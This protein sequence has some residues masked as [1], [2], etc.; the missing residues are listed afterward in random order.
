[1]TGNRK[2]LSIITSML[3]LF[4]LLVTS[5][6]TFNFRDFSQNQAIANAKTTAAL[7]RDGLTAHMVSGVMDQ[8][9]L[10]LQNVKHSSGAEDLWLFRTQKVID[11]YGTGFNNEIVRDEIDQKVIE[12]KTEHDEITEKLDEAYL[13]V[14]IPYIATAYQTP[15]CLQCHTD[16]QEGDVLGGI[17]MVFAI[18]DIRTS[19]AITIL[20]ILLVSLVSIIL[21]VYV[22]H[23]MIGPYLK[24]LSKIQKSLENANMGDYSTRIP[25]NDNDES[26][27]A[28]RWLNTLLEKLEGTIGAIENNLSLFVADRKKQYSDPLTKAKVVIEDLANIYKFKKTIEHDKSKQIIYNRLIDFF[29]MNLK[30]TDLS[31]Y[32]VYSSTNSRV[33]IYDDTPEKFCAIADNNTSSNCRAYR[34]DSIVI[35]DDFPKLCQ[36]CTS[37]KEY[38]C[39]NFPIDDNITLV[40]NIKPSTKEELNQNKQTIGYIKNYLESAK[41]VLQ[42][43]ILNEILQE[44][45]F[46]D[47]LTG[48]Q[49]RKYLD[50]FMSNVT[51][52]SET[53][54]IIMCDVDFFKKINDTYGHDSGD[55]VI[56]AVADTLQKS[57]GENDIAFRFGGEEFVVFVEDFTKA[58]EIAEKIRTRFEKLTFNFNNEK[59]KK[60]LS[61]GVAFY[62][63]DAPTVWATIK[64]AD[65]A[66]YEAKES[67][68]NKVVK[69]NSTLLD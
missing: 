56:K 42:S 62:P 57:I 34:T 67:G 23:K 28:A 16:A 12:S 4:S 22:A 9:A 41:P 35:S 11:Q 7:I 48:L 53:F 63:D 68:R 20:K 32:E 29:K 44:S 3:V 60:T 27:E 25:I 30:I 33:L 19:G 40:V 6:V 17:S 64:Y 26:S 8:R 1:M 2:I 36:A 45:N 49:N 59:V 65:I 61:A 55:E 47:G 37:D 43:K 54:G 14:T 13:R 39:L 66:L 21:F 69:F 38:L 51:E 58:E 18:D 15:N 46:I 50:E 31:L 24:T 5:I 10:F 52:T